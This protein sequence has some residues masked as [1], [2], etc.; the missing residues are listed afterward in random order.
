MELTKDIVEQIVKEYFKL[1]NYSYDT[2][3]NVIW[4]LNSFNRN[5]RIKDFREVEE[6]KYYEY[7]DYLLKTKK[8]KSN[9]VRC[10]CLCLKKIFKIL[11]EEEK[12]LF[13]PFYRVKLIKADKNIRDKVISE[14]EVNKMFSIPD[15]KNEYEFRNRVILE[16]FYGTGV[17][18]K[19]LLNLEI[20]DFLVEERLIFVKDGKGKR[21]RIIPVGE[22]TYKYL[23]RYLREV[24]PKILKRKRSKYLFPNRRGDKL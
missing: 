22:H 5:L 11:E 17:R 1:H 16:V 14:E 6:K 2:E 4:V 23:K 10:Y 7:L 18:A 15:L 13:N 19:E 12:I 8:R 9:T 24:R 21:D 20:D 3:K